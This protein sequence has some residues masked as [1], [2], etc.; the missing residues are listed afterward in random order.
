[1]ASNDVGTF[2][3]HPTRQAP[4]EDPSPFDCLRRPGRIGS[5]L[6]EQDQDLK[7]LFHQ[8]GIV[9]FELGRGKHYQEFWGKG[10]GKEVSG[11]SSNSWGLTKGAV[12]EEVDKIPFGRPYRDLVKHCLAGS[13]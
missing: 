8:L 3:T 13:L 9:L 10:K 11:A 7:K 12:L 4:T 5:L 1:L 2:V 6:I